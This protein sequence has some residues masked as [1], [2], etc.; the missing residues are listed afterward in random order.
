MERRDKM[1][2]YIET[3]GCTFNQGDSQIIAG[4]LE[5][6]HANIVLSPYDSDV[7]ILNTCYVKQPTEKK[8]L[9]RIR[10]VKEQ[11]PG[12]KL[13]IAGCMVE[14]DPLKLGEVAP[15]AGWIGPHRIKSTSAVVKSIL[16]GKIVRMNGHENDIKADLPKM[17]FNPLIHILQIC[18]GCI[19]E[20]T[21]CCTRFARGKLQSYP[22]GMIKKE[23]ERAVREGCVELQVT[24]QDTAAYGKDTGN[25]LSGLINEIT[26][27]NGDFKL[28]IGMM[29]PKSMMGEVEKIINAFKSEKVYKF[30]HI[31]LQSGNDDVLNDMHR[32]HTVDSFRDIIKRFRDEIP[33]ISIATDV[34]VGY[35]TEGH[36]AFKDTLKVIKEIKPDFIHISKYNH[37]PLAKSSY[38]NVIDYK[39]IKERSKLINELKSELILKNNQRFIG[40]SQRILITDKGIKGGYVGRTDSYKTVIVKN[41]ELGSFIDVK[42]DDA[43]GTYLKGSTINICNN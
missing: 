23:A 27:I 18:E 25:T 3:F 31:P 9:N 8:V 14:I 39:I 19:G 2:I 29:H 5:E 34:I 43:T 40:R 35:P 17:R 42:I 1:K 20:C 15:E 37:R 6:N 36:E 10:K 4:L 26:S 7:I 16:N 22:V 12:K 24:A 13:I 38:M 28:R 30:L 33:E 11:F 32:G 21:Y 41:A